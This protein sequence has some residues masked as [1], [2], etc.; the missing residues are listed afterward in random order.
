MAQNKPVR[1]V[2]MAMYSSHKGRRD[3]VCRHRNGTGRGFKPLDLNGAVSK[4]NEM[5]GRR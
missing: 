1:A 4:G 3:Y 5:L 2:N